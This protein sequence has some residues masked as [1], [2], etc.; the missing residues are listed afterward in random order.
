M[1]CGKLCKAY[2]LYEVALIDNVENSTVLLC[3]YYKHKV[4]QVKQCKMPQSVLSLKAKTGNGK[5]REE[6]GKYFR[7]LL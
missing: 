6:G 7:L 1:K 4:Y 2:F 5:R 3:L